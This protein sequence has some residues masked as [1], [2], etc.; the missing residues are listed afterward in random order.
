ME[1]FR[2]YH[3]ALND[4][5]V[6]QLRPELFKHWVNLLCVA[7]LTTPRGTFPNLDDVSFLMRLPKPKIVSIIDELSE[8]GLI[9]RVEGILKP[10]N[11]EARQRRSDD[12]AKR[13]AKHRGNDASNEGGNNS[14]TLQET[15]PV[16]LQTPPDETLPHVRVTEQNRTEQI[17]E[18]NASGKTSSKKPLPENGQA[19]QIVAEFCRVSG[20]ERPAMYPKAVGQA[21]QLVK[22]GITPDDIAPLYAFVLSWSD[23]AD[24]G[25]LLNQV[26]KWRISRNGAKPKSILDGPE[27]PWDPA[28]PEPWKAYRTALAQSRQP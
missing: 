9:D 22:A 5:K 7:N 26:D 4:P 16:T 14:V 21:G 19:Q 28:N 8:L 20:I 2:F 25:L 3:E 10:H 17:T 27:P 23:S 12:V 15:L 6:Q 24:L 18:A 1:W 11:W 13:V